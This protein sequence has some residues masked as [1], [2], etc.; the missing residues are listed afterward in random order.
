MSYDVA[1]VGLTILDILGRPI[2]HIPDGGG[3]S[4]I[5]DIRL[6][7]AGT[8]AG[9]AVN[10]AKLGL[11][12]LL[13]GAVGEDEKGD[14]VFTFARR[15]GIDVS[16]LQRVADL[17]T[18]ATILTIRSN[19]DRPAFHRLGASNFLL[20]EASDYERVLGGKFLHFGGVGALPRMDGQP[21]A[22]L[23][24]AAKKRGC[25][26]TC[27]LIAPTMG[28]LDALKAA[29]PHVDYFM[30]S[31]EEAAAISGLNEP[32]EVAR[33]YM[34]LGAGACVFKWGARGSYLATRDGH[35]HIPAFKVSVVDTTGCGDSYCAGFIAGLHLGWPVERACRLATAASALVAT[36]LGTDA[37]IVSLEETIKAMET[38]PVL[39]P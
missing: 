36:G 13:V 21:T 20:V 28:T 34:D 3:V 32:A 29:L 35:E 7:I 1:C 22:D 39:V 6:T 26:V 33:F 8:A 38:L 11:G 9:A 23:L 31:L 5:D 25:T 12:T 24:A 14:L 37:G 10:C 2:D 19:G 16:A 17:P 30:P 18:S 4:L 15:A 27:D